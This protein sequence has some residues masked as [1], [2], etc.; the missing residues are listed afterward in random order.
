M[1]RLMRLTST[2]KPKESIASI[3]GRLSSPWK[4][5]LSLITTVLLALAYALPKERYRDW[6]KRVLLSANLLHSAKAIPIQLI[7]G[8]YLESSII[9]STRQKG[10]ESSI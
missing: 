2:G 7:N 3:E 4:L 6:L 5:S 9:A 8:Q 10:E 1:K